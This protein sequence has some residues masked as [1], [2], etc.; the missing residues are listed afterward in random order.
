MIPVHVVAAAHRRRSGGRRLEPERRAQ[1]IRAIA[2]G[3]LFAGL[4]PAFGSL[5]GGVHGDAA[6]AGLI[7]GLLSAALGFTFA[8]VLGR[9]L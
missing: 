1:V 6:A 2:A 9:R 5:F 4:G 3:A 7:I 8:R